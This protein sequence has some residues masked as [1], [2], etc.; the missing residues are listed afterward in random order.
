MNAPTYVYTVV[1]DRWPDWCPDGW[2]RLYT[3]HPY[4]W[5]TTNAVPDA[6][7]DLAVRGLP[8]DMSVIEDDLGEYVR[9]VLPRR[10]RTHWLSAAAANRW[11][12]HAIALGGEAH[13]LRGRVAWEVDPTVPLV[14]T[15][16]G[17]AVHCPACN[18]E[19]PS[20]W[21]ERCQEAIDF[22]GEAS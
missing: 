18:Q 20:G 13:V 15:C 6:L 11:V 5:Q 9:I 8:Y 21:C 17:A 14:C 16:P 4:E 19:D 2:E 10:D 12:R 7:R 22:T 1:V 3:D